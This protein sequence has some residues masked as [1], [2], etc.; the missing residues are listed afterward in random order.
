MNGPPDACNI[1]TYARTLYTIFEGTKHTGSEMLLERKYRF[2]PARSTGFNIKLVFF[3][4]SC[5]NFGSGIYIYSAE[6][7]T[8]RWIDDWKAVAIIG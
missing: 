5:F 3:K 8:A 1:Y 7:P 4:K 2:V 6:H